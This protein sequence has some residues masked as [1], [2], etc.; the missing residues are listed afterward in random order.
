[1]ILMDEAVNTDKHQRL[2]IMIKISHQFL[3]A[4]IKY[5]EEKK[6][7]GL[8]KDQIS[9]RRI[10]RF[11]MV[12]IEKNTLEREDIAEIMQDGVEGIAG[13]LVGIMGDMGLNIMPLKVIKDFEKRWDWKEIFKGAIDRVKYERGDC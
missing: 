6:L 5:G 7:E 12:L 13:I 8:T 1:M 9:D 3:K 4:L 2:E 11:D 10:I